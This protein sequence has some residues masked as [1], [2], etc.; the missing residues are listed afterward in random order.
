MSREGPSNDGRAYP[1]VLS[2]MWRITSVLFRVIPALNYLDCLAP[3]R[4]QAKAQRN[5]A[6]T[7][8]HVPGPNIWDG[9]GGS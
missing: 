2:T 7:N 1:Q 8:N 6:K 5:K 9:I 4:C 3:L